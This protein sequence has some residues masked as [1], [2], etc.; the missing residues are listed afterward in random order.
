MPGRYQQPLQARHRPEERLP[1]RRTRPQPTATST[2]MPSS[3]LS[4]GDARP[5]P[6]P[7][8]IIPSQSLANPWPSDGVQCRTNGPWVKSPACFNGAFRQR[9]GQM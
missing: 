2:A 3:G 4:G 1:G 8:P 9:N 5:L 6:T 7:A